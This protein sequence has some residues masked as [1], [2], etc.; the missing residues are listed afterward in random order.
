MASMTGRS[1]CPTIVKLYSVF[2]GMVEYSRLDIR[3]HPS[4]SF[5]SFDRIRSLIGGQALRNSEKRRVSLRRSAQT[6]LA[7]H[8]PPTTREVK[9]TGHCVGAFIE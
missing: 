8:L 3:P 9:V 5:S 4:S 6:I 2:G 1:V 7:F